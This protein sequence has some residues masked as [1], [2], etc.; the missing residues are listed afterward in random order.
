MVPPGEGH[1][2]RE[3]EAK[4]MFLQGQE[5]QNHQKLYGKG[6]EDQNIRILVGFLSSTV[7]RRPK[8]HCPK[9]C[10]LKRL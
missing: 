10:K 7:S 9:G 5:Q 1:R 2:K 4:M 8:R 6:K 3:A